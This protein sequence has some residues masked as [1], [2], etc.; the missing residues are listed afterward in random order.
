MLLLL[1]G[2][3]HLAHH[4]VSHC[5]HHGIRS[6][7]VWLLHLRH[8]L[9]RH[10]HLWHWFKHVDILWIVHV[11]EQIVHLHF[12]DAALVEEVLSRVQV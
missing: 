7:I 3:L 2:G 9:L 1:H 6:L 11:V 4:L 5:V 10:H 8:L 12:T